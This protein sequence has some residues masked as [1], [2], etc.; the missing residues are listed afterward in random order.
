LAGPG[1]TNHALVG[2]ERRWI[3]VSHLSEVIITSILICLPIAYGRGADTPKKNPKAL[4]A[5]GFGY[6]HYST[7]AYEPYGRCRLGTSNNKGNRFDNRLIRK[8]FQ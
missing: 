2:P 8:T 5:L 6:F 4:S 7:L 3:V 1:N